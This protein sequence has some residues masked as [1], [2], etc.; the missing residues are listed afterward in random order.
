MSYKT[1]LILHGNF[2][3]PCHLTICL[4][5]RIEN[6]IG[7]MNIVSEPSMP[8]V[9]LSFSSKILVSL[10][11]PTPLT[12]AQSSFV[13]GSCWLTHNFRQMCFFFASLAWTLCLPSSHF[14]QGEWVSPRGDST[15][16][17]NV[18]GH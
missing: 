12:P 16:Q 4:L 13:Q 2:L 6:S 17:P 14:L 15:A 1:G 9:M 18:P 7:F 10:H 11:L 8:K 5:L 3:L